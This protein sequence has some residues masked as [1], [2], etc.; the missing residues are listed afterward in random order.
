MDR[1]QL[2]S[3]LFLS[4]LFKHKTTETSVLS[5]AGLGKYVRHHVSVDY[6]YGGLLDGVNPLYFPTCCELSVVFDK[7]IQKYRSF[8]IKKEQVEHILNMSGSELLGSKHI[9]CSSDAAV[10]KFAL[11]PLLI[12]G[13]KF[14]PT[15]VETF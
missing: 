14:F 9:E 11:C 3:S 12:C 10:D 5:E 13:R 8:N 1:R 15:H 2:L 6:S 7:G 4:P